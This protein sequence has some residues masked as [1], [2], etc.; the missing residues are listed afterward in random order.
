M[1]SKEYLAGL[2]DG[3][4]HVSITWS[5]NSGY[6]R[7]PKLCVKLTNSHLPVIETVKEMYGGHIYKV[8]KGK[9]TYLQVY[10]I[11]LTVEESKRFLH[12]LMP[13][14]IIKKRQAELALEFSATIYRRGKKPVTDEEIAIRERTMEELRKEKLL[15]WD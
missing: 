12:D 13:H 1:V 7:S 6:A 2:F 11:S 14:L 10:T 9:E 5:R 15:S 8:K 3:E 4:G